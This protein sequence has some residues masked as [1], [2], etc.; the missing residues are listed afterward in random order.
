MSGFALKF[1]VTKNGELVKE[2]TL[3]QEVI[4]I[5]RM[6]SSHLQIDDEGVSKMHAVFEISGDGE[7]HIIDLGSD[8]GTQVNGKKVNI[9]AFLVK[10]GDVVEVRERSRKIQLIQ[11]SLDAVVRRGVPQWLDL[12]KDNLKGVVKSLPVREDLTM[13]MQEQLVVELYSK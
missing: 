4:K 7:A 12:E 10:I 2:A 6:A 1:V 13:P 3:S 5:G 11:D 9:P 8:S